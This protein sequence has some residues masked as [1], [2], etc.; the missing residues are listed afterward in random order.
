LRAGG[1][2]SGHGL[3]DGAHRGAPCH[4]FRHSFATQLLEGGQD[5]RVIQE[6]LAQRYVSTAMIYR[7]VLN[8][9]PLG[10]CRTAK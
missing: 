3:L 1:S 9:G 7:P 5:I 6:L 10:V 4:R 8:S 2:G